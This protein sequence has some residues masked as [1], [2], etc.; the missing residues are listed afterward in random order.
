MC[1]VLVAIFHNREKQLSEFG[2]SFMLFQFRAFSFGYRYFSCC[3]V[4]G[5]SFLLSLP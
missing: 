3:S 4:Y 2:Y 1:F 5:F